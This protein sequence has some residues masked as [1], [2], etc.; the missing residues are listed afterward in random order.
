VTVV[1][2]VLFVVLQAILDLPEAALPAV[3]AVS[4]LGAQADFVGPLPRRALRYA[5]AGIASLAMLPLGA[6][7]SGSD[8]AIVLMTGVVVFTTLYLATLGGPFFSARFPVLMAY[9]LAATTSGDAS[10]LTDRMLG[11]ALG[12]AAI[13]IG[14]VVLWPARPNHPCPSSSLRCAAPLRTDRRPTRCSRSG[15]ASAPPRS[16]STCTRARSRRTNGSRPSWCTR[17]NALRPCG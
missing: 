8:V 12:A 6:L 5:L 13:A 9:L 16:A 10:V 14:A 4:T 2:G 11:W 17:P 7:L 1:A 3:F 15:A